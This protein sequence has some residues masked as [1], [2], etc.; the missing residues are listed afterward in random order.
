MNGIRYAFVCAFKLAHPE[1]PKHEPKKLEIMGFPSTRNWLGWDA[2]WLTRPTKS[3][4]SQPM[5][6]KS[7]EMKSLK[8]VPNAAAAA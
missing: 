5:A 6:E 8:L 4:T 7:K 1:F 3:F 2:N